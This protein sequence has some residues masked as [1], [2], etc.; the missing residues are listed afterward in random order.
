VDVCGWTPLVR[1]PN[2]LA[3]L[4]IHS[5]PSGP[6]IQQGSSIMSPVS[7]STTVFAHSI[8]VVLAMLLLEVMVAMDCSALCAVV[9]ATCRDEHT[10]LVCRAVRPGEAWVA[11]MYDECL[12]GVVTFACI[13]PRVRVLC[14]CGVVTFGWRVL[15]GANLVVVIFCLRFVAAAFLRCWPALVVAW[16]YVC[17]GCCLPIT[18][19]FHVTL[20][21]VGGPICCCVTLGSGTGA[22]TTLGGV[23]VCS[24]I[25]FGT[26][27]TVVST[28]GGCAIG[29]CVSWF[30][31]MMW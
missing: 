31:E 22:A 6:R 13:M 20:A 21:D 25:R 18:V 28:C 8:G 27:G 1:R 4:H 10:L 5:T 29:G 30:W 7:F 23:A 14:L 16:P 24:C 26:G 12:V 11:M 19:G 9:G 15:L 2:S 3:V 17:G